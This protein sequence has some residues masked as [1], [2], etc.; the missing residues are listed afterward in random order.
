MRIIQFIKTDTFEL[1]V[2]A[3]GEVWQK[4][5]YH[6]STGGMYKEKKW[7]DWEKRD[8][9]TEIRNLRS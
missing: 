2:T 9:D 8:L 5:I 7:S 3:D 6:G 4:E 1:F